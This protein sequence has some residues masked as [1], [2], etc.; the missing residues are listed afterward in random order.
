MRTITSL[1]V[2]CAEAFQTPTP[3]NHTPLHR[4]CYTSFNLTFNCYALGLQTLIVWTIV[5]S[6][7]TKI[8]FKLW[9]TSKTFQWH[10]IYQITLWEQACRYISRRRANLLLMPSGSS[11]ALSYVPFIPSSGTFF[12]F[13][14]WDILLYLWKGNQ[15]WPCNCRHH[16]LFI[17]IGSKSYVI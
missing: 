11:H 17:A 2:S 5:K 9:S 1:G 15:P 6:N 4:L 7:P 10:K 8:N 16:S 13:Y 3:F 14:F 12:S